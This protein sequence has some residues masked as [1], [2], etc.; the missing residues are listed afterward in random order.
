MSDGL[1]VTS[2]ALKATAVAAINRAMTRAL[3]CRPMA[4][5]AAASRP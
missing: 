2:E 5:T 4:T 1:R 3:G